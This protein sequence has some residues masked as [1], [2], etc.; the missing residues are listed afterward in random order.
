MKRIV[1]ALLIGAA[2]AT[3][4]AHAED[5][6]RI[7][8][9]AD[10]APFEYRDPSG[11]LKGMEIELGQQMCQHMRVKC[12]WV[13]MDFDALIPALKAHKIDAAL[14]QMSVNP[15]RL[16]TVDFSRIFTIAPVQYVAKG[17][18]GISD[19]PAS[20][21]GK[22]VGV[23]SGS[24]HESYLKTRLPS[25]SSGIEMKVYQGLDQAWLDLQAG[26]IQ[27]VLADS[28]VGLDWITKEGRKGGFV[29][30]GK[31]VSDPEIF[32]EGTA[33]AVRKGDAKLKARFDQAIATVLGNGSFAAVNKQ[34]FPFSIAPVAAK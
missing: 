32:G 31:P 4:S 1:Q 8:T 29:L 16:K 34:Y 18:T 20:L 30:V 14:A 10:Y 25:A 28:T 21:R 12:Q 17:L 3:S 6:V 23:Q 7:G 33:V 9:L 13:T 2:V 27:A 24:I 26:R 5:V 11:Q 15:E 19:N 22:T